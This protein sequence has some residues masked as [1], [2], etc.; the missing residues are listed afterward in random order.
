MSNERITGSD[1][2]RD[3]I[4]KLSEGNPGGLT[5]CMTAF[6][7]GHAIDPM[8]ALGGLAPLLALDTLGI[9]G[10][11]IWMLYKD[12]CGE[13]LPYFL[14]MLRGWQLG[15]LEKEKLLFAIDNYGKGVAVDEIAA[16]VCDR[17]PEFNLNWKAE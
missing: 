12:V 2:I 14:A 1:S 3:M 7:N 13:R 16:K 15:V 9:Y 10:S 8:G 11:R 6:S 5:V 4:V 17:I